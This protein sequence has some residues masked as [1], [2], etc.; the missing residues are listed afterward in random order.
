[1]ASSNAKPA[2]APNLA[3]ILAVK[4][5][6]GPNKADG[7]NPAQP[8]AGAGAHSQEK[9]NYRQDPMAFAPAPN[10]TKPD[11]TSKPKDG[12]GTKP[13]PNKGARNTK[14][15]DV[16]QLD[17]KMEEIQRK[18]QEKTNEAIDSW[19]A[20]EDMNYGFYSDGM[21]RRAPAN[22]R[23]PINQVND[24]FPMKKSLFSRR[25]SSLRLGTGSPTS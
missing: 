4:R 14:Q 20:F 25:I 2:P 22:T 17:K 7:S 13:E 18:Q 10:T 19:K 12:S 21:P 15:L 5:K 3:T 9:M 16:G 6:I 1:M 24:L 23:E 8:A 11:D